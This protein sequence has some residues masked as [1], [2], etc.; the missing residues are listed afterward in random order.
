M[1]FKDYYAILGV[2]PESPESEIK[3]AYR[4]LARKFHPDVS[5]EANAE[6]QFKAINEAYEALRDPAKRRAYDQ[7]RTRGYRPGEE[8]RPPP[9]FGEGFD[10]SDFAGQGQGAGFSDFFES[11]FGRGGARG[12]QNAPRRGQDTRAKLEID[13]YTA[14]HGGK[15]RLT[16]RDSGGERV[17]D[18]K[19]PPGILPGQQI[20]LAGQGGNPR[21]GAP[22]DMLLE[23]EFRKDARYTL[24]GR[25]LLLT[26][27]VTPWE[28]AL[29]ATVP[30]PTMGGMVELTIPAGS[31][32]GKRL[33]LKG[34]GW[35]GQPKGDQL[36]TLQVH[37]PPANTQTQ[38]DLYQQM[39]REFA[40]DPRLEKA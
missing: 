25:N 19:I 37:A 31:D 15:Q 9:D 11:L 29:G 18:V 13:L 36:V 28:A 39:A 32:S 16:L 1:E 34:R 24:E 35:P 14:F 23:I 38:R 33:R 21:G 5:K 17:L 3:S 22:G 30:V 8:F 40:F 27:P 7:L 4:R 2:K 26:L 20:R 6:S 12:P 10:F